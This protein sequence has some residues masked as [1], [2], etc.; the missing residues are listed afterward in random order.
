MPKKHLKL[1]QF[2]ELEFRLDLDNSYFGK[3]KAISNNDKTEYAIIYEQNIPAISGPSMIRETYLESIKCLDNLEKIAKYH[4][5]QIAK[6]HNYSL[7][8]KANLSAKVPEPII[9]DKS[10]ADEKYNIRESQFTKK[11]RLNH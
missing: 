4:S 5:K 8:N 3:I 7:I 10:K 2:G 9:V 11:S 1:I 6:Q